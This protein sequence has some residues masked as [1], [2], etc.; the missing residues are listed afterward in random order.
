[1]MA[2]PNTPLDKTVLLQR[3]SDAREAANL[4]QAA[5]AKLLG[6]GR[7]RYA[8]YETRSVIPIEL[9]VKAAQFLNRPFEYFITADPVNEKFPITSQTGVSPMTG[10]VAVMVVGAVQA[11][12]F[13]EALEWAPERQERLA[14]PVEVPYSDKPLQALKVVGPSMNKWYPEGSYVVVV[15]TIH[16]SAGWTPSTGQ[17]VVVQRWNGFGEYEATVKEVAYEG[18]DLLLWPR[19]DDPGFQKAWKIQPPKHHDADDHSEPLRITGLVVYSM[20]AAPGV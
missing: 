1:M 19:S 17:H 2:K 13:R 3:L 16:L 11:G 20:R 5:M 15:P 6:I 4:T 8:K 9:A 12:M 14:I 7:D 10:T 18:D